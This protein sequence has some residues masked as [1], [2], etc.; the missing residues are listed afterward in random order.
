MPLY[1]EALIFVQAMTFCSEPKSTSSA[2]SEGVFCPP[3]ETP[4]CLFPTGFFLFTVF[5]PGAERGR[6]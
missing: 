5:W 6:E 2:V 3:P 4:T 1:R